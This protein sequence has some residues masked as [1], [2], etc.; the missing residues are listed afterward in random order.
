MKK[1]LA[2][3]LIVFVLITVTACNEQVDEDLILEEFNT[4]IEEKQAGFNEVVAFMRDN[5]GSL[6][7]EKASQMLLK[8]E[9][10]H[11]DYITIIED[12][13]FIDTIQR[14]FQEEYDEG[15]VDINNPDII[16]D[17]LIKV[18]VEEAIKCGYKV[19]Q[20]EAQFF[21]VIDYSFYQEFSPYVEADIEEYFSI[22]KTES[23]QAA[24]RDA[25][26]VIAWD[27]VI[28]RALVIE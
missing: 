19:E 27:E 5:I 9:D 15:R 11:K 26:L 7:S 24:L 28:N 1:T 2:T 22:M 18:L 17:K 12:C 14:H 3:I 10:Y 4:I 25:E 23:D 21:P 20:A 16:K 8:F 6:S 13:F